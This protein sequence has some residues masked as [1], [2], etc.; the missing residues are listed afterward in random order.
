M[1][2]PAFFQ[3]RWSLSTKGA[4]SAPLI[5]GPTRRSNVPVI[6]VDALAPPGALVFDANDS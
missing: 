3:G 1:M 6:V 2:R 4:L 5:D